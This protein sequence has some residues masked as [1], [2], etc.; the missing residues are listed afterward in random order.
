[1]SDLI[2]DRPGVKTVFK[3][4]PVYC[5]L[6]G[7]G[8]AVFTIDRESG[9]QEMYGQVTFSPF[10]AWETF[11]SRVD[12][13]MQE[14]LEMK[15]GPAKDGLWADPDEPGKYLTNLRSPIINKEYRQRCADLNGRYDSPLGD[16]ARLRFDLD[17]LKK[18]GEHYPIPAALRWRAEGI[19]I[20]AGLAEYKKR[21]PQ[22]VG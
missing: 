9:R 22:M 13:V 15:F 10:K 17:M 5:I 16:E 11:W 1:M 14:R 12:Q 7:E 2:I 4:G 6:D 19:K 18:Y 21:H 20:Q 3:Y 8:Y